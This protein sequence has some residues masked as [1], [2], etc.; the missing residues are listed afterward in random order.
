MDTDPRSPVLWPGISTKIGDGPFVILHEGASGS[1]VISVG[2]NHAPAMIGP[3]S[4]F[5]GAPIVGTPYEVFARPNDTA[6]VLRIRLDPR[7]PEGIAEAV[8]AGHCV[9]FR[10]R[11]GGR[12]QI[13]SRGHGGLERAPWSWFHRS[14]SKYVPNGEVA[15]FYGG[16]PGWAEAW[17]Y[18]RRHMRNFHGVELGEAGWHVG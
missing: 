3:S 15:D 12:C 13:R 11:I 16:A 8:A 10:A 1:A 5:L 17:A 18:L 6:G 9:D 7:S 14:C 4:L 2:E